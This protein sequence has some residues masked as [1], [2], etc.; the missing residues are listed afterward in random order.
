VE[1]LKLTEHGSKD[2]HFTWQQRYKNSQIQKFPDT[3]T[4]RYTLYMAAKIHTLHGRNLILALT[5]NLAAVLLTEH[6]SET[7]KLTEHY[8][9]TLKLTE[10]SETKSANLKL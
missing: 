9:E 7:L 5:F 2:T 8:S 3:K 4:P 10:H 6:Y 1:F